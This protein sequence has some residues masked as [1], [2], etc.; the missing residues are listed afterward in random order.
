VLATVP[1]NATAWTSAR[2]GTGGE[3]VWSSGAPVTA[4][5]TP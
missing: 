3:F 2:N 5:L 1:A 4:R